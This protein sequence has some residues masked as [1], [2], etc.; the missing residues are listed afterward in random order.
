MAGW[1]NSLRRHSIR[2]P[3]VIT[4]ECTACHI[5]LRLWLQ[6]GDNST[7]AAEKGAVEEEQRA[8]KRVGH[9][10]V[11]ALHS[12]RYQLSSRVLASCA[13]AQTTLL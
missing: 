1:L 12:F 4:D 9:L 13:A 3:E 5:R 6:L 8:E 2:T 10:V 11:W 7:A